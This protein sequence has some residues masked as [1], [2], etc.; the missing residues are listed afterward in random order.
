[1]SRIS[2]AEAGLTVTVAT[3]AGVTVRSAD[4]DFPSLVAMIFAVPTDTAVTAPVVGDTVATAGLSE[5][6]LTLLPLRMLPFAS[7]VVAVACDV[8]TAVIELGARETLTEATGAM[9]TVIEEAPFFPSLVA[10]MVA[11]PAA[12]AVTNPFASTVAAAVL[13]E[14]H[15]TTRPVS[16]L[17]FASLVTAVSCWVGLIPRT[18]LAAEGLTTTDATGAA[19]TVS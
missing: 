3:G 2:V 8:P 12:T 5:L 6:Q 1:M 17:P 7:R 14:P 10:V 19:V 11:L 9:L 18:R 4:P 16:V 13:F 15:V